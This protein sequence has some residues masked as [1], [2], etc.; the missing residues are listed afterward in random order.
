M[1][2]G[3]RFLLALALAAVMSAATAAQALALPAITGNPAISPPPAVRGTS[4]T[5]TITVPATEGAFFGVGA[6]NITFSAAGSCSTNLAG[7]ACSSFLSG[8]SLVVVV[9]FDADLTFDEPLT[10]TLMPTAQL[11]AVGLTSAE[12]SPTFSGLVAGALSAQALGTTQ[13]GTKTVP[14]VFPQVGNP[15]LDAQIAIT[16]T[17]PPAGTNVQQGGTITYSASMTR[18][19]LTSQTTNVG[20]IIDAVSPAGTSVVAPSSVQVPFASGETGPKTVSFTVSVPGTATPGATPSYRIRAA[21]DPTGTDGVPIDNEI[22]V[23]RSFTITPGP[24]GSPPGGG[25]GGQQG[26]PPSGAAKCAGEAATK[27]GTSGKDVLVGTS[28]PD[29]I[30]G[31]AGKDTIKGLQDDDVAC[32]GQGGDKLVGGSGDDLLLGKGGRDI[33]KGKAGDDTCKGGK[34]SDTASSC[35]TEQSI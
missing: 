14:F 26:Q 4:G 12:G 19:G 22:G 34:K 17:A 9:G 2:S 35:E 1:K 3:R 11:A 24:A 23:T 28:G 15:A 7:A 6:S 18:G 8:G 10:V 31:L 33:L 21:Y 16:T 13:G 5:V 29:V 30:L 25:G 27:V 20:A 32:G